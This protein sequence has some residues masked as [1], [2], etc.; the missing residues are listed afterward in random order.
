MST[1]E[2]IASQTLG[3]AAASVTFSSIPQNYTDLVL[4]MN[5][6]AASLTNVLTCQ[7]GNGSIDTGTNYSNTYL[8]GSGTAQSGRYTS[9]TFWYASFELLTTNFSQNSIMHFLNYSNTATFKTSLTRYN[10]ASAGVGAY[11]NLWRSTSAINTIRLAI[12]GGTNFAAGST[13]TIYGV[14]A[15]NSSAKA[16]GGNIVTTDGT[17]WYHA[18]TSSGTFIPNSAISAD[19]L[20]IGGG[21][22][23][24]FAQSGGGGAGGVQLL[25][26]QSLATTTYP[27]TVGAGGGVFFYGLGYSGNNSQFGSLTASV[28]GGGG[29]GGRPYAQGKTGGSGGGSGGDTGTVAGGSATSGQGNNGGSGSS[30]EVTYRSTGGGGGAGGAGGNGGGTS[31][32]GAGGVGTDAYS[33]WGAATKTGQLISSTYWYA[34]GGGG[35]QA[36]GISAGA[37]S[38][39]GGGAGTNSVSGT[40]ISGLP[41]TGSGGGAGGATAGQGGSGIVIVRYAV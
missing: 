7:V 25:S 35:G 14:S 16:S 24:G 28:G 38:N 37:G 26:S 31:I 11:V 8:A 33:S 9:Q 13:F 29:G 40:G 19:V 15:G 18:F 5:P 32:G 21:G 39:G 4:V 17:Y 36:G 30:D 41:N 20:C 3:S 2:P 1:Y 6:A 10:E 23:G 22:S 12:A 27:V 34:G